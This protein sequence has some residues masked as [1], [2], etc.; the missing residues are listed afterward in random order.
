MEEEKKEIIEGEEQETDTLETEEL[1]TIVEDDTEEEEQEEMITMTKVE[2]EELQHKLEKTKEQLKKGYKKAVETKSNYVSKE[3]VL[4]LVEEHLKTKETELTLINQGYSQ[5]DL[6]EI[7]KISAEKWLSVSDAVVFHNWKKQ[8]DP[9]IKNQQNT[10]W[11]NWSYP[12]WTTNA[13]SE[14]AREILWKWP[15]SKD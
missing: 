8:M 14:R 12:T 7:K 3:D 9:Q 4:W 15:F 10:S 6:I 1:E 13:R 5:E 2:Y 11:L